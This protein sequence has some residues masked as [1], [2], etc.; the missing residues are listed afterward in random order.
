MVGFL[1]R[2]DLKNYDGFSERLVRFVKHDPGM[3][4][5]KPNYVGQ[6]MAIPDFS[7]NQNELIASLVPLLSDKGL[8]HIP[9]TNDENTLVGIVT[10]SDLIADLYSGSMNL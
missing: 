6:I 1:K 2:A 4:S 5:N 8:H 7:V 3:K 9:V 10:Q